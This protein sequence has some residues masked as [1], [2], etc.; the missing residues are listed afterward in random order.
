VVRNQIERLSP[1][2]ADQVVYGFDAA[3]S[4]KGA[5]TLDARVLITP[6]ANVDAALRDLGVL[7]VTADRIVAREPV[8]ASAPPVVLWSRHDAG[9]GRGL[10]H[11][12]AG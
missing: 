3:A 6:R 5:E 12:P 11:F 10:E 9:S 1:W 7:G 4:L 8:D 2:P